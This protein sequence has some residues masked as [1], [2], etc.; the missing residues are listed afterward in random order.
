MSLLTRKVKVISYHMFSRPCK[1][2]P[3][4]VILNSGMREWWIPQEI[5]EKSF[6]SRPFLDCLLP[7]P[8]RRCCIYCRRTADFSEAADEAASTYSSMLDLDSIST[9]RTNLK[10]QR[11]G[12]KMKT[13]LKM[14]SAPVNYCLACYGVKTSKMHCTASSCCRKG[15]HR[16][17][18]S[19]DWR[20][21]A[22]V[23]SFI[24]VFQRPSA[25]LY[26]SA[27]RWW[28]RQGLRRWRSGKCH[29]VRWQ[30]SW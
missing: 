28:H 8:V 12:S 10:K 27:D 2:K 22:A 19:T 18:G 13:P 30:I 17:S 6:I 7:C 1:C 29:V 23:G 9:T 5:F 11:E 21:E 20:A 24:V 14:V 4:I 26:L 25:T 15:K 3:L 16:S